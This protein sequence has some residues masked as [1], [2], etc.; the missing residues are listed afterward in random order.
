MSLPSNVNRR[1]ITVAAGILIVL[2]LWVAFDRPYAPERLWNTNSGI[3]STKTS[4]V[5]DFPPVR[6]EA[7][8]EVCGNTEWNSSLIFTCDNNRDGI[9]HVRNS[10]LNCAR[11]AIQAGAALVLPKIIARQSTV[12]SDP[13]TDTGLGRR[14][15]EVLKSMD[16]MFD[17]DHFVQSMRLSCPEMLLIK[18]TEQHFSDRRKEL[19][20]ETLVLNR[21]ITGMEHPESWP[22]LFSKWVEDHIPPRHEEGTL[23]TEPIVIDLQQ[24]FLSYPIHSDGHKFAH[25][26]GELLKFR[27]DTRSLAT[28]V[29]LELQEWHDMDG[30]ISDSIITPSFFGAHLRTSEFGEHLDRRHVAPAPFMHY[31]GQSIAYLEHAGAAQISLMYVSSGNLL[32]VE[33]LK[34]S[35]LGWG[36]DITHKHALLKGKHQDQLRSLTWDQQALVDFLVLTKS[37]EFAGVGHSSFSWNIALKRQRLEQLSGQEV[38]Q[39]IL[40]E[41]GEWSDGLSTLYG[42][43][44]GYVESAQCMWE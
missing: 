26:F 6:S 8:Q 29:L 43:R 27:E 18:N 19:Q 39:A 2:W 16:Y 25:D 5:F 28:A 34:K 40:D 33:R 35:A 11:F 24:S 41:E 22:S 42:V 4:D 12:H 14:R 21:P 38:G 9:G 30:N 3:D 23:K 37:Q 20:P 31:D 7:I 13:E 36:I 10:I 1:Y 17:V 44:N 15:G 32:D